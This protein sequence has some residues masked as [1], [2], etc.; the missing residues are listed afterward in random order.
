MQNGIMPNMVGLGLRAPPGNNVRCFFVCMCVPV[1]LLNSRVC[2]NDFTITAFEY[3]NGF[4]V[5][6]QIYR[7]QQIQKSLA[8]AVVK[9]PKS[10]HT[11]T[12]LVTGSK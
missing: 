1:A 4:D 3:G 6:S 5:K 9:A 10:R 12:H 7:L 11:A 2:A 8:R